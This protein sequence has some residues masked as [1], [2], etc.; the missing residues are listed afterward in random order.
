MTY[1][2][3]GTNEAANELRFVVDNPLLGSAKYNLD[4]ASSFLVAR[5]VRGSPSIPFPS[6]RCIPWRAAVVLPRGDMLVFEIT[7]RHVV[8]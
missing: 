1:A 4:H 3:Y 5:Q 8:T 7:P 6:S 2:L